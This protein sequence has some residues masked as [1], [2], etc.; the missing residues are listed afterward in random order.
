M[1]STTVTE[2]KR[3]LRARM[4]RLEERLSPALR[5][6]SDAALF[7]RLRALPDFQRADT[8]FLFVGRGAEPDT[9]PLVRALAE[10][11]KRV[12]LPRCLPGREMECRLFVPD[13]PLIPGPFGIP[14]PGEDAPL[15]HQGEIGLALV[16]ALCYDRR[17]YRL[18]RGG[19][20]YDRWLA[21]FAGLRAGLCRDEMLLPRVPAEAHDQPVHLVITETLTLPGAAR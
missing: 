7:A 12:A 9:L 4:G 16:P 20:Y 13:T 6:E 8:L 14:E 1:P 3:A 2:E 17:G 19:G 10:E 15:I 5:R 18:G 21:G 11:G